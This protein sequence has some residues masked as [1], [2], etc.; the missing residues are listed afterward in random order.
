MAGKLFGTD[1]TPPDLVAKVTGK[2][3]Y[4][5]DFRA[6]GM[7]FAKLFLSPMPHARVR[8]I[9]TRAALAMEGVEAVLTADDL[10]AADNPLDENALT[11]EPLYQG[12]PILAVAAVDE[13]TA[14][15]AIEKI[16]V[17]LEPLP[18]VIDPLESLRPGG[19][20]ARVGGNTMKERTD[21]V[22]LKWTEADF[23][24]AGEQLPMGQAEE[25]W[26]VGDVEKGL[27]E[28]DYVIDETLFH[29]S[30][31]H[32]PL[33]PRS[34]M[35]YWQNDKL[36]IH[37]ST[38]STQRTAP[39]VAR[40]VG[41]DP[42]QVVLIAEYCGGGFGSKI[43]GTINMAIP[44]LLSKKVNGR[45]VMHRV[46]RAEENAFGRARPGFQGRVKMGFKNDGRVTAIDLYIVQDNGP[47]G[48]QGDM[49]SASRC[50]SIYYTPANM[51]FRGVSVLTNTPPR[52][53]QRA[54][55]GVQITAML[56]PLI[57][58]A[59]KHLNIDRIAIRKLNAPD[60]NSLYGSNQHGLTSAYVREALDK[61]A[62]L[63]NWS[64][65]KQ[66]SGQVHG[67]KV[68]GVGVALST[69]V[70]GSRGFDGILVIK[71]D[72]KLY[73]HQGIGNLG[74]HSFSDTARVASDI[75]GMPWESTVV[76]WGDTSKHLPY[77]SVQAGSQT[78]HAHTRANHAAA[79]DLKRK[80]QEIAAQD[81]GGS[82]EGY[83]V[84]DGRVFAKSNP[85]RGMSLVRAAERAIE[86]GGRFDGHEVAEDLNEVTKM[87]VAALAGQGVLGAAKDNYGGEG[88]LWS[89]VV[90]IAKV[91]VDRETGVVS[92]TDYAA[93]S[94]VGNVMN[95][96]GLSAQVHGGSVQGFGLAMSQ[97]WIYD[98]RW[99]VA[100]THR[101]Y[102]AK[103]PSILDVPLEMK[104]GSV[105]I[106]DPQTPVGAKGIGEA[107]F[108][109]G[110]AA[111]LCAIQDAI[112][113]LDLKR[114]PMMTDLILNQLE[115][116]AQPFKVLA[117]HV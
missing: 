97:K 101:L 113:E 86:L 78:T 2:A 117:T 16:K 21:L 110:C 107:P 6:D 52:A 31:T 103:P 99:G 24:E 85:G 62:E 47:Y 22:E 30:Q 93:V 54:P 71:P 25:E 8:N 91:E 37:P 81:L 12:E 19:P 109:A 89:F 51:R 10:P 48:R 55:G 36:Y 82:P 112:G 98:P 69:Y 28:A 115:H 111:V 79:M 114:S 73:V 80:L 67:T 5:E 104:A 59:A 42:S 23:R 49:G 90:G 46:S 68:T 84:G 100:S 57:D 40:M 13:A 95:P 63:V 87:S 27:E 56:E 83:E 60:N 96:R 66:Q 7:L 26:E 41:V 29:Q 74:T 58:K 34:C 116:R 32:H 45:P 14:A 39:V 35:A 4:A 44:A 94:D 64:E 77:S 33:E 70:A 65:Y 61:A 72:G 38:Q 76:L 102:T 105:E 9:D 11:N 92:I 50:A 3:K 43:A 20:N 106:P 15:A 88:D 75:L 53:A 108:G 17:D 1:Y 18:F